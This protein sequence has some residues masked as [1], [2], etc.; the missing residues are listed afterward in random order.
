AGG[1]CGGPH[2][3]F[4]QGRSGDVALL[5]AMGERLGFETVVAPQVDGADGRRIGASAIREALQRGELESA[6][7]ALGRRYAL[8]GKVGQGNRLGPGPAVPATA[9]A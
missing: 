7:A 6:R 3:R 1:V 8:A 2:L 5:G 9:R 4:G